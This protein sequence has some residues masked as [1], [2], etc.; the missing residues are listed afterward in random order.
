VSSVLAYDESGAGTPVVLLHAFPLHAAM[1]NEQR[2]ALA[3]RVRVITPDLPGFGRSPLPQAEPS[4]DLVADAVVELLDT[5][6]LD[7]VVLGGLSLGGYVAMAI[8]RRH[9]ERVSALILA[10]TKAG[11]DPQAAQDNR[12]RIAATVVAERSMRV[13]LTDV[14]P[15]L[16]GKR[17]KRR[18]GEVL[19]VVTD[20][21]R[22]A[23]P[24]SIAWIQRAMAAR[25]DSFDTLRAVQVPALVIVGEDD[26]ISPPS[27]AEAM[28]A[29]LPD[30][31]LVTVPA[32]GH[33]SAVEVPEVVTHAI[34]EFLDTLDV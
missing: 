23:D 27:D 24:A 9:P 17:T 18:R 15:G 28:V 26:E 34:R 21:I 4:L 1:W 14:L 11:A 20:T 33:L 5:L 3:D 29:A 32:S 8:L 12:E 10:D 7:R 25:P 30:A 22:E 16:V 31:R 13:V 2:A 19:G 6:E